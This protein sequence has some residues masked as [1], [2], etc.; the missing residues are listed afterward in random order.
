M[1]AVKTLYTHFTNLIAKHFWDHG[2]FTLPKNTHFASFGKVAFE[3]QVGAVATPLSVTV[4][5]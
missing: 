4:G 2:T 1:Y 3:S 5:F